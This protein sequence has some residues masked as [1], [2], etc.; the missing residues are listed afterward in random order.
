VGAE[1]RARVERDHSIAHWVDE[2]E[3]IVAELA[4]R[5]RARSSRPAQTSA[6]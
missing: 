3:R 5:R 4:E 1:L 6:R 2:V